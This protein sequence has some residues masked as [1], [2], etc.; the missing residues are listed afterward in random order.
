M[1]IVVVHSTKEL[2][3]QMLCTEEKQSTCNCKYILRKKEATVAGIPIQIPNV[4]FILYFCIK[5]VKLDLEKET[6][7]GC[8]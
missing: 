5:V 4:A 1:L 7:N 3:Q 6:K 8:V 2:P